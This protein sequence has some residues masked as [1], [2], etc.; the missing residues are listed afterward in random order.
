MWRE[1]NKKHENHGSKFFAME[2]NR[3]EM[4]LNLVRGVNEY[5]E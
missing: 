1:L 5:I 3:Q 4:G 2:S